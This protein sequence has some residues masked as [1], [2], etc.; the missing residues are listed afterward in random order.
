[1]HILSKQAIHMD[2]NTGGLIYVNR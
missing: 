1:M 2:P